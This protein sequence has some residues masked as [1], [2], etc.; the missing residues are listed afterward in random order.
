MNEELQRA[1]SFDRGPLADL[2]TAGYEGYFVPV[3]VDEAALTTMI[4]LWDI[5]LDRSRVAV[6]DGKPAGFA[7]LAVRGERAWVGGV[8]VVPGH[9]RHGLGRRLMESILAAAPGAVTLEVIEQ[10]EPALRLY[11]SLG[12]QRT[13][14]LEVWSLTAAAPESSARRV[15]NSQALG[16]PDLPWQREDASLPAGYEGFETDGGRMLIRV[17]DTGGRVSVLQIDAAH[18]A[19]AR[20]L[21]AAGRARGSSLHFVNVPAGDPACAAL[22]A[23]GGS[24]D[25]RQHELRRPR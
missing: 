9:R 12:F 4:D 10:N 1:S 18:E 21:L 3:H 25:L 11:E 19:A 20:D 15:A 22:A 23:L 14:L 2:F 13:R 7:F 16:Q 8:G 6:V 17:S 24:L 5:D